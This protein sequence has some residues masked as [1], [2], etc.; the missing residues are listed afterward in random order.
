M[1]VAF[2]CSIGN[3][4]K[5][6]LAFSESIHDIEKRKGVSASLTDL[7]DRHAA[8]KGNEDARPFTMLR[9]GRKWLKICQQLEFG[10][11]EP[12]RPLVEKLSKLV[13]YLQDPNNKDTPIVP[14][15]ELQ[16]RV[17]FLENDEI[18]RT[19]KCQAGIPPAH[20]QTFR[21]I[22]WL[23][24][25]C[26]KAEYGRRLTALSPQVNA[27]SLTRML[28]IDCI[29]RDLDV[30]KMCPWF[31]NCSDDDLQKVKG[32]IQA[33]FLKM[34][35]GQHARID[36]LIV[37]L[38]LRG[39]AILPFETFQTIEAIIKQ[40][41]IPEDEL[42]CVNKYL[43]SYLA[44]TPMQFLDYSQLMPSKQGDCS[45]HLVAAVDKA[46]PK[47]EEAALK[48]VSRLVSQ[49]LED[50]I[51]AIASLRHSDE[52]LFLICLRRFV[53]DVARNRFS[54]Q[55]KAHIREFIATVCPYPLQAQFV[56]LLFRELLFTQNL[57]YPTAYE[58]CKRIIDSTEDATLHPMFV[59]S[60]TFYLLAAGNTFIPSVQESILFACI[61]DAGIRRN[62]ILRLVAYICGTLP[63]SLAKK[64]IH[65]LV[66]LFMANRREANFFYK[67]AAILLARKDRAISQQIESLINKEEPKVYLDWM[68]PSPLPADLQQSFNELI[69]LVR[70]KQVDANAIASLFQR[71]SLR[72][73]C[74]FLDAYF[75]ETFRHHRLPA[76]KA[77]EL[78]EALN[79]HANYQF[80]LGCLFFW[81]NDPSILAKITIDVIR[82]NV[83]QRLVAHLSNAIPLHE[84]DGKMKTLKDLLKN[85]NESL[86]LI[87]EAAIRLYSKDC[88]V[89]QYFLEILKSDDSNDAEDA[90]IFVNWLTDLPL[91][92]REHL[93]REALNQRTAAQENE[94]EMLAQQTAHMQ[95]RPSPYATEN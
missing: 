7:F 36:N 38:L 20:E 35:E 91:E 90:V 41:K 27:T 12:I 94:V 21:A 50:A 43:L 57:D 65:A 82:R 15:P 9:I 34:R 62:V 74:R 78:L 68:A 6:L 37:S 39:K 87:K 24:T 84:M 23:A 33:Y 46:N 53:I 28:L 93:P 47:R 40:V 71:Y 60:L 51:S 88:K 58:M 17:A 83:I 92:Q 22:R 19:I 49:N 30:K 61:T 42:A 56:D 29:Y 86:F 64:K 10:E 81:Q 48:L 1:A 80:F 73:Q 14:V 31:A 5:S 52:A 67:E 8:L 77:Y 79:K 59:G 70:Q 32:A 26:M 69:D 95:I 18:D 54:E 3:L 44:P 2:V 72:Q 25:N 75:E 66:P 45:M 13:I 55:G 76:P 16:R 85:D 89:S 63:P 11:E 4:Q